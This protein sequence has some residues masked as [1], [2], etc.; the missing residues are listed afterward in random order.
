MNLKNMSSYFLILVLQP[1]IKISTNSNMAGSPSYYYSNN[2]K[3]LQ[4][5]IDDEIK[6][7]KKERDAIEKDIEEIKKKI[8]KLE[9]DTDK[10][11]NDHKVKTDEYDETRRKS[12]EIIKD[13]D[14]KLKETNDEKNKEKNNLT[15]HKIILN[16]QKESL[17]KENID[18]QTYLDIINEEKNIFEDKKR[19]LEEVLR[20][21]KEKAKEDDEKFT[22]DQKSA[23]DDFQSA[24]KEMNE[25]RDE[26]KNY[27]ENEY[28]VKIT[29]GLLSKLREEYLDKLNNYVNDSSNF[30]VFIKK[31]DIFLNFLNKCNDDN[32]FQDKLK[33]GYKCLNSLTTLI[34]TNVEDDI[35]NIINE[36]SDV[37]FSIEIFHE[38]GD[39][40][41][42]TILKDI[43]KNLAILF[44]NIKQFEPSIAE[45]LS[46][47]FFK[48]MN[49]YN[50][51]T[52]IYGTET[53][54]RLNDMTDSLIVNPLELA[55]NNFDIFYKNFS[56]LTVAKLNNCDLINTDDQ[57]LTNNIKFLE[58][59]NQFTQLNT[60]FTT[61]D[62]SLLLIN[63]THDMFNE[64]KYVEL[65]T[66]QQEVNKTF[67]LDEINIEELTGIITSLK[68][69][70][71]NI[72][73]MKEI[74]TEFITESCDSDGCTRR[75]YNF[76]TE[77]WI[78]NLGKYNFHQ[79]I[80]KDYLDNIDKPDE[81][82]LVSHMS[83]I[84]FQQYSQLENN[85]PD[86]L[87]KFFIDNFYKRYKTIFNQLYTNSRLDNI[88]FG[89]VY[90]IFNHY[91]ND[92]NK[93][94][95][96]HITELIGTTEQN[97]SFLNAINKNA[98]V[99]RKSFIYFMYNINLL[100]CKLDW[101][102]GIVRQ[103]LA[104]LEEKMDELRQLE[105]EEEDRIET[106]R[107]AL[108]N[109]KKKLDE[110]NTGLDGTKLKS[111]SEVAHSNAKLI[112][113]KYKPDDSINVEG[114]IQRI[115]SI[116]NGAT[117]QVIEENLTKIKK[118]CE[119]LLPIAKDKINE[120][121]KGEES[122]NRIQEDFKTNNP[123]AYNLFKDL[124]DTTGDM[125]TLLLNYI[126]GNV[127][128][129]RKQENLKQ[130]VNETF[131]VVGSIDNII[132]DIIPR[133]VKVLKKALEYL[134]TF[135]ETYCNEKKNYFE[136]LLKEFE[137]PEAI[138]NQVKNVHTNFF[139]LTTGI[140]SRI[141]TLNDALNGNDV[142]TALD[143]IYNILEDPV[144]TGEIDTMIRGIQTLIG[145]QNIPIE[146]CKDK[147]GITTNTNFYDIL[148]NF[149]SE[150][151][152]K[153][154]EAYNN[155]YTAA[156]QPF[157]VNSYTGGQTIRPEIL[158]GRLVIGAK[159]SS[160]SSSSV[161]KFYSNNSQASYPNL[162][163]P[164][165]KNKTPITANSNINAILGLGYSSQSS[166]HWSY[167]KDGYL[168]YEND[169]RDAEYL[170][171][172]DLV[173]AHEDFLKIYANLSLVSISTCGFDDGVEEKLKLTSEN[174]KTNHDAVVERYNIFVTDCVRAINDTKVLFEK[175]GRFYGT[176]IYETLDKDVKIFLPPERFNPSKYNFLKVFVYN[177]SNSFCFKTIVD[178]FYAHC[179]SCEQ[180]IKENPQESKL[181]RELHEYFLDYISAYLFAHSKIWKHGF[182]FNKLLG[183]PN[184]PGSDATETTYPGWNKAWGRGP[185][186][187]N[188]RISS[189]T[190]STL[191]VTGTEFDFVINQH[192]KMHELL[193]PDEGG[194][195][196]PYTKPYG[197]IPILYYYFAIDSTKMRG[198]ARAATSPGNK[199][200]MDLLKSNEWY[201]RTE[202]S[203]RT[204][205]DKIV[206]N[207]NFE[208]PLFT[209]TKR[210]ASHGNYF[211]FFSQNIHKSKNIKEFFD[212]DAESIIKGPGSGRGAGDI[213]TTVEE[214][215]GKQKLK[216][217]YDTY[218]ILKHNYEGM[219]IT[220][221]NICTLL[222][223]AKGI[224][225]KDRINIFSDGATL[226][227]QNFAKFCLWLNWY[228]TPTPRDKTAYDA[229][230]QF[231]KIDTE[232]FRGVV[233]PV[234]VIQTTDVRHCV[235]HDR[236]RG[237]DLNF[238]PKSK[239]F[240][241]TSV[242]GTS[243]TDRGVRRVVKGS[244]TSR[245]RPESARSM[246]PSQQGSSLT[247]GGGKK[248]KRLHKKKRGKRTRHCKKN[249]TRPLRKKKVKPTKKK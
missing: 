237:F 148:Q 182:A 91:I 106:I 154:Q 245:G 124:F 42:G 123:N 194:N 167:G 164:L 17:E 132:R 192:N 95:K 197:T 240:I 149:Q 171:I 15:Q 32:N 104:V 85:N 51:H 121:L 116:G 221:S 135:E 201:M 93:G 38:D 82:L 215:S 229:T 48:Y 213:N 138:D 22:A 77:L 55:K 108:E 46:V 66:M 102:K 57:E 163:I 114:S 239:T 21:A 3:E 144:I 128:D 12:E 211:S 98:D 183:D 35:I 145:E 187:V 188:G 140:Y 70:N 241:G 234:D 222:E 203:T 23:D 37:L 125:K 40:N 126:D 195:N 196:K 242:V 10:K 174:L 76:N 83:N 160:S 185:R 28:D 207:A 2:T 81:F 146:A 130:D 61:F 5:K 218:I 75:S 200:R 59:F 8:K 56:N 87:L 217:L 139:N 79:I 136:S 202:A 246:A 205:I 155:F 224:R 72:E 179:K 214:G 176:D 134:N 103:K 64:T 89:P 159:D 62:T 165:I 189:T 119:I 67:S 27:F 173:K 94:A 230:Q 41:R 227:L 209:D 69:Y 161:F 178:E 236:K 110:I 31:L 157:E 60:K 232:C 133:S 244:Q 14:N 177:K 166:D 24:N 84:I 120:L 100:Y 50:L 71:T 39:D 16:T 151:D 47:N 33:N 181:S 223:K 113:H 172:E 158:R 117:K 18:Y 99:I 11:E 204:E 53:I 49:T 97:E 231:N 29:K 105:K 193:I 170:R 107:Q 118:L 184:A 78:V 150:T 152:K 52:K 212:N 235:E 73:T 225:V 13:L 228:T 88:N 63:T 226:L 34:E 65:D 25:K 109:Y 7:K 30:N 122:Y 180:L 153:R 96:D 20:V 199:T 129:A 168:H 54:K 4:K 233:T 111:I 43:F 247:R 238:N 137:C 156:I 198:D 68:N 190:K 131:E 58:I 162:K 191:R 147:F 142:H 249:Q 1:N 36:S 19:D 216:P 92:Q 90:E 127:Q 26:L 220:E 101:L 141:T 243:R 45:E 86:T 206:T 115:D 6:K 169:K 44:K 74:I 210:G 248:T 80:F 208:K 9:D 219:P 112:L 143:A 186:S 175:Y